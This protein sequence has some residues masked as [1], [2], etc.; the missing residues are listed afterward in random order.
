MKTAAIVAA[1]AA[2]AMAGQALAG[3]ACVRPTAPAPVD[4]ATATKD[5]LF[6]G[7]AAVK[8]FIADSDSFQTCI[9]SS[10]EAMRAAAK[11]S[12]TKVAK[13]AIKDADSQIAA[14]QKDKVDVGSAFNGAI[15]A[16]KAANPS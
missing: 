11:A 8:A 7:Q 5:Q 16:F 4:G 2:L 12:K 10:I 14:N 9:I 3:E 13:V 6:A 1:F 15:K